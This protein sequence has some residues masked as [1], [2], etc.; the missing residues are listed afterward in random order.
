[1]HGKMLTAVQNVIHMLAGLELARSD[2]RTM[3][4]LQIVQLLLVKSLPFLQ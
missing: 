1:M 3:D 2:L 4:K